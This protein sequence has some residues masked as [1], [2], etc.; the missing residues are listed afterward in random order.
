MRAIAED[1]PAL[2]ASGGRLLTR[3][4]AL[5]QLDLFA[6]SLNALGISLIVLSTISY[7]DMWVY[8][9]TETFQLGMERLGTPAT[10]KGSRSTMLAP[11]RTHY[12]EGESMGWIE[13][14]RLGISAVVAHGVEKGTLSR[15]VGHIPGTSLPS[16]GGNVGL[17]AHRDTFFRALQD[18][19]ISD[20]IR[21]VMPHST[22]VYRVQGTSI[23]RPEEVGVLEDTPLPTLTLVTCYPFDYLGSAP[24]RYI[25]R[26]RAVEQ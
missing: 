24:Y 20:S 6:T 4:R 15:A 3:L 17:A 25:V 11:A 21:L 7:L 2:R 10:P 8:Q 19:K 13:I 12:N 22:Y 14:P 26:A 1:H 16:E 18:V 23:V 9:S 5:V